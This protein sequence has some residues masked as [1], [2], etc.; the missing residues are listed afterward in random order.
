MGAAMSS[1]DLTCGA[2]TRAK[3]SSIGVAVL[4][5]AVALCIVVHPSLASADERRLGLSYVLDGVE[6]NGNTVTRLPVILRYLHVHAGETID[7]DDPA[8]EMMR[9]RLLGT[10]FFRDVQISLRRGA[11]RGHAI[12]VLDVVERNTIVIN[13]VWL[14]LAT[15][16]TARGSAEPL[17]PYAGVEAAETNLAGTGIALGGGV[18]FADQQLALRARFSDSQFLGTEWSTEAQLFFSN[19]RDFF[20]NRDAVLN[21]PSNVTRDDSGV[22]RYRRFGGLVGVGHDLTS[23]IRASAAYRL[24]SLDAEFP[25]S[26]VTLGVV[27]DTVDYKILRGRSIVSSLRFAALRDTRDDPVLPRT[28]DLAFVSSDISMRPFG[29]EYTFVKVEAEYNRWFALPWGHVLRLQG[30]AG[31]VFGN[32]PFMDTF[33]VG[34]LSD[35]LPDRV[36]GLNFDRRPAPNFLGTSIVEQRYGNY[37]AKISTE[38]RVPIYRGH[39]SIYGA[40]I[41]GSFGFYSLTSAHDLSHPPRGY[42]GLA[43]IPV[44]I[45]FNIGLRVDTSAGAFTLGISNL[46]GLIP[47]R[48]EAR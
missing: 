18:A 19:G 26:P 20:I 16:A 17:T 1:A 6:V 23:S 25:A 4:A 3:K 30:F 21:D 10:G 35:L 2:H 15:A 31:G 11:T 45:T 5:L 38:Y 22:V 33:Y 32:A 48:H 14:G 27:H 44:D 29:S 7:V 41:F 43:A 24:E 13:G 36:L 39:R 9:Y 12:L 40:D 47:V 34:D 28:G 8:L 42:K 46:L 37:A